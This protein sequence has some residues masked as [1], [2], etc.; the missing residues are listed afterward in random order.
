MGR[1]FE[2]ESLPYK[3]LDGVMDAVRGHLSALPEAEVSRLLPSNAAAIAQ[4]FPALRQV[5]GS[6][7]PSRDLLDAVEPH[8][9]RQRIFAAL[10]ELFVR[11]AQGQSMIVVIDDMQWS[12]I[13]SLVLLSA[14]LRPPAAPKM[15]LISITRPGGPLAQIPSLGSVLHLPL[16]PLSVTESAALV[17]RLLSPSAHAAVSGEQVQDATGEAQG[18]PMFLREMV[19][20]IVSSPVRRAGPVRLDEALW[21]RVRALDDPTRELIELTSIAGRPIAQGTVASALSMA[22]GRK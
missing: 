19:R 12:D 13:D 5:D 17:S 16:G 10:R 3:A 18:H 2:R 9:Q 14:L 21:T 20:Q 8:V 11:L 7:V 4:A 6:L 22:A 15:L 1:C